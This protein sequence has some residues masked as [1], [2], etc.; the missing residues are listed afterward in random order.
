MVLQTKFNLYW[1]T[2]SSLWA[3]KPP[4]Y[5]NFNQVFTF[6]ELLCPLPLLIL[7]KFSI[8]Q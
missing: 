7:A 5:C 1:Y 4:K 2:V 6:W 8:R 3:K